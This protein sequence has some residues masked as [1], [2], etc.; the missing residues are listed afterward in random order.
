MGRPLAAPP[1]PTTRTRPS[2][3]RTSLSS[4]RR[5]RSAP[6]SAHRGRRSGVAHQPHAAAAPAAGMS[7]DYTT[8]D[9]RAMVA[10]PDSRQAAAYNLQIK[11]L[12]AGGSTGATPAVLAPWAG[13]GSDP[14]AA[15]ERQLRASAGSRG[16]DRR[17]LAAAQRDP[18]WC[19]TQRRPLT[20]RAAGAVPRRSG[21]PQ[22]W[23]SRPAVR[24]HRARACLALRTKPPSLQVASQR[25][26]ERDPNCAALTEVRDR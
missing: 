17:E 26:R 21:L 4:R 22:P 24:M 18:P 25:A 8:T 15:G 12:R 14:G 13:R 11:Q 2:S 10:A 16:G 20:A 9:R 23:A 6:G 3:S 1:R 5:R 19:A 7:T